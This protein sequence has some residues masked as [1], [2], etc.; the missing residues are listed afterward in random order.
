MLQ[1]RSVADLNRILVSRLEIFAE[2]ADLVVGI[3]RS[4]M[5]PAVLLALH[6]DVPVLDLDSYCRGCDPSGGDRLA[7]RLSQA[8]SGAPVPRRVLVIDDSLRHGAAMSAAKNRIAASRPGS[9][10]IVRFAAVYVHPEE[11]H[12]VDIWCEEM[13]RRVF[14]W[15]IMNHAI[16]SASC[17]DIDGVLCR[18][19]TADENDDGENY[20]R[21]LSTV[22]PLRVPTIEIGWLVTS[23]LEKY[24]E[25]TE[26]WLARHGIGYKMLVMLDLP[27]KEARIAAGCHSRFKA[28]VYKETGA[29]LF[30]ESDPGQARDIAIKCHKPVYCTKTREMVYHGDANT[31]AGRDRR[32]GRL[33][34]SAEPV[35]PVRFRPLARRVAQLLKLG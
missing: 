1:Y 22:P 14:E 13:H 25:L 23:R 11:K 26:E 21:F 15:N 12:Q 4:G 10:D 7:R 27:S 29:A 19:P 2:H 24:R 17:V 28:K 20:L 31:L 9:T 8:A 6:L 33:L 34:R 3:P 30:I 35:I 16:L 32:W 5:L 18:D